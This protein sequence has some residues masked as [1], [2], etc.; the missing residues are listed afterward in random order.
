[1][2]LVGLWW[3]ARRAIALAA[4]G[5]PVLAGCAGERAPAAPEDRVTALRIEVPVREPVWSEGEL[6]ALSA[7]TGQVARIEPYP[8]ASGAPLAARTTLSPLLPNVGENLVTSRTVRDAVYVPQPLL[9]RV[10]VLGLPD[11]RPLGTFQAGPSPSFVAMDVG[12]QVLLAL[13]QDGSTV[14]GVR[15]RGFT[16]LPPQE[17][18]AGP[19]A[20]LDGAERGR[21]IEYHVAGPRGIAHY[22]GSAGSVQKKDGI[23][24]S[25]H[26][27]AG[28]MA[29]PTRLYVAEKG[30]G[31][32][33]AVG[34]KPALDGLAVAAEI[35]LGEPVEYL[36]VDATRIY[37][38]TRNKLVVL[39]TDSYEGYDDNRFGIVDTIDFRRPLEGDVLGSAPLS[40]LAVGQGDAQS[41]FPSSGVV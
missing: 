37:A 14:T 28:D 23:A 41:R 17:V 16:T 32:L 29:K 12:S 34:E 2:G 26:R 18:R 27:I 31:R 38:A 1:M 8:P 19:E 15:V 11:L 6:L 21:L 24:L 35:N 10:A 22:K 40:G 25:A 33:L 13:S 3:S 36:G 7:G 5:L 20:E 39:E 4:V 9:D 30:T